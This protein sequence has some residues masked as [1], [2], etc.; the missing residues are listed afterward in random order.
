MNMSKVTRKPLDINTLKGHHGIRLRDIP[1]ISEWLLS[2][3]LENYK[4]GELVDFLKKHGVQFT[5]DEHS[6]SEL[7]DLLPPKKSIGLSLKPYIKRLH[8]LYLENYRKHQ[9]SKLRDEATSNLDVQVLSQWTQN[10]HA[11][12]NLKRTALRNLALYHA[13]KHLILEAREQAYYAVR[14]EIQLGT[15]YD[16]SSLFTGIETKPQDEPQ[17]EPVAVADQDS[18]QLLLDV[19]KSQAQAI[20]AN[21]EQIKKLQDELEQIKNLLNIRVQDLLRAVK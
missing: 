2:Y 1:N 16:Q 7:S 5:S 9:P 13:D 14:A 17:D 12:D 8:A 3:K 19:I 21:Y 15:K 18:T 4:T 11:L 20:E 6:S 10:I